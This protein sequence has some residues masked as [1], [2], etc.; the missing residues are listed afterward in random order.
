MKFINMGIEESIPIS[1]G[2]AFSWSK[3]LVSNTPLVTLE[4]IAA[5]TPSMVDAFRLIRSANLEICCGSIGAICVPAPAGEELI[6]KA[7]ADKVSTDSDRS[8]LS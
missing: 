7:G 8:M 2:L 1:T 5:K 4:K 6:S 3:K